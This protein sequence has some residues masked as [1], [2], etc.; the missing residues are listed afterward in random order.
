LGSSLV[1]QGL[2]FYQD[3]QKEKQLYYL[4]KKALELNLQLVDI[5]TVT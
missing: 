3:K 4:K 5:H 1:E 2:Q